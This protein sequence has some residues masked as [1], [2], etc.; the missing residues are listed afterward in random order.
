MTLDLFDCFLSTIFYGG[1]ETVQ[2]M[3]KLNIDYINE[4]NEYGRTAL[5][6]AVNRNDKKIVKLLLKTGADPNLKS[7]NGNTPLM[8]NLTQKISITKLLLKYKAD[9]HLTNLLNETVLDEA[10]KYGRYK[11]VK[12]LLKYKINLYKNFKYHKFIAIINQSIINRLLNKY[13]KFKINPRYYQNNILYY[14]L[15]LNKLIYC[16]I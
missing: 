10:I 5:I 9:P 1:Y 13:R 16:Y 2:H 14:D 11:H 6:T 7:N 12:L 3:V 8:I 15:N 4:K